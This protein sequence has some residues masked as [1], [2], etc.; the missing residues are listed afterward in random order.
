[1]FSNYCISY[2]NY[3]TMSSRTKWYQDPDGN[4]S[5]T[6]GIAAWIIFMAS[7][8]LISSYIFAFYH[9][10]ITI[11]VIGTSSTAFGVITGCTLAFLYKQKV[12]ETNRD[13]NI[14]SVTSSMSSTVH[15]KPSD[16]VPDKIVEIIHDKVPDKPQDVESN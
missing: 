16:K 4:D 9:P 13:F 15:D 2:T 14:S 8:L 11:G 12:N 10:D 3:I 5:S 7:C 6:R 1:L